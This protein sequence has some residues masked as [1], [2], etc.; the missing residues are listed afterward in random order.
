MYTR[1]I[2]VPR[3]GM[4]PRYTVD[5]LVAEASARW[6]REEQVIDDTTI[7]VAHLR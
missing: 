7:I 1:A 5:M 2:H 6:L 4:L 3:R